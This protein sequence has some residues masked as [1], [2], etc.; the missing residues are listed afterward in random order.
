M[1]DAQKLFTVHAVDRALAEVNPAQDRSENQ[2]AGRARRTGKCCAAN[3]T[4]PEN[5]NANIKKT[6]LA[7]ICWRSRHCC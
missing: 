1:F 6:A 5:V 7:I 3:C 4:D 2:T